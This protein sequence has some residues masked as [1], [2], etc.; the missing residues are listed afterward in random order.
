M[1]QQLIAHYKCHF[2][3]AYSTPFTVHL[4]RTLIVKNDPTH[5]LE[6]LKDNKID[7]DSLVVTD[8]TKEML[9][10]TKPAYTDPPPLEY[11]PTTQQEQQGYKI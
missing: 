6:K 10:W 3:Q 2:H 5:Y 7:I 9:H 8:S 11:N 1:D 4:L